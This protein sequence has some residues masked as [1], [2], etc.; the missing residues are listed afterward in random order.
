DVYKRQLPTIRCSYDVGGSAGNFFLAGTTAYVS[1]FE[2]GL[3]IINVSNPTSP[4]LRCTYRTYSDAADVQVVGNLAYVLNQGWG[5]SWRGL[6][7]LNVANPSSPT[8]RGSLALTRNP[9]GLHVVGTTAY[10]ANETSGLVTVNVANPA[11]PVI[12]GRTRG[13]TNSLDVTVLDNWAF[14]AEGIFGVA[15]VDVSLP[16][17]PTLRHKYI[18]QGYAKGVFRSGSLLYVACDTDGI[19]VLDA[20]NPTSLTLLATGGT[21]RAEAENIFVQRGLIYA[22]VNG[23]GFWVMEYGNGPPRIQNAT[24]ND[25]NLNDTVDAGDQLVLTLDH[26]VIVA[27]QTLRASHFFLPVAGDSLGR[28]GFAVGVNPRNSRQISIT[29]GQGVRLKPPGQFSMSQR[30][31]GSPS[32]IDFATSLPTNAIVSLLGIPATDGGVAGVDDSGV[33]VEYNLIPRT[34]A[35]GPAG[36]AIAG[37]VSPDAA[38]TQHRL[39]VGPN[40]LASTTTFSLLPPPR[41]LGAI[42]AVR[43]AANPPLVTFLTPATLRLQY[44]EGDIDRERGFLE[45]EMKVHQLYE[46]ALG[47]PTWRVLPGVHTL[48]A[49]AR[50]VSAN[51]STL[52]APGISPSPAAETETGVFAGL[53]IETVDERSATMKLGSGIGPNAGSVV[54]MPGPSG[55]YTLHKLEFPNYVTTSPGDPAAIHVTIRTATLAERYSY[56]GGQSF[57]MQSG[58]IFVVTVRN[59]QYQPIPFTAPVHITVQFKNR[60]DPTQTDVVR[61]NGQVGQ[62]AMMRLGCDQAPNEALDFR[63][64]NAAGQVVNTAQGTVMVQNYAGLAG[65]DGLGIFGAVAL[66]ASTPV[67]NWE[68]YR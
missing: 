30:G 11:A 58:A 40:A 48:N 49:A 35:I 56:S 14:V 63:F 43:V 22:A 33:D 7:I 50:T 4:T 20:S 55:A 25:A 28:T 67:A 62:P 19:V 46:G 18:T 16:S 29:L 65:A 52:S 2:N 21:A 68:L 23:G 13:M 53:P 61:F 8:V 59:A 64:I 60:T 66:D 45:S 15:V 54:L 12:R 3:K 44:R 17:S 37:V 38:Y 31:S 1:S 42:N 24:Y 36:G 41:N 57:P 26:S 34:A 6:Q 47:A 5:T 10:I 39:S 32:G 27:T 51:I 9:Q